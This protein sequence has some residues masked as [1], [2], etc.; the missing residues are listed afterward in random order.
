MRS[1]TFNGAAL[2]LIA[3]EVSV[4]NEAGKKLSYTYLYQSA[5]P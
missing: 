5:N 1:L 4:K 3:R 2:V